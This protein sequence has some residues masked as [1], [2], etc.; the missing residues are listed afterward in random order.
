MGSVLTLLQDQCY[1]DDACNNFINTAADCPRDLSVPFP[2]DD[3][4]L[5]C[6]CEDKDELKQCYTGCVSDYKKEGGA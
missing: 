3:D 2:Q 4:Y 5:D 1:D 6:I